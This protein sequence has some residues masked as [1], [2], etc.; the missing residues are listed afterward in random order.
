MALFFSI[1]VYF[2]LHIV[3]EVNWNGGGGGALFFFI[4]R[5]ARG[6]SLDNDRVK[7]FVF[8]HEGLFMAQW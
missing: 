5:G 7:A 8:T 2:S 1:P 3:L 4:P 6:L